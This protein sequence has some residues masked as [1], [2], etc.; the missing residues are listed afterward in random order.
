MM[1]P[2][3][4]RERDDSSGAW[5]LYSAREGCV[6]VERHA[7]AVL[8]VVARMLANPVQQVALAEHDD[9]VES[10]SAWRAH[11]S[12]RASIL[13]RRPRSDP[14]LLDAEVVDPGIEPGAVDPALTGNLS[15]RDLRTVLQAE[16][17]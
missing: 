5:Q 10:L 16:T 3:N 9:V 14:N 4:A 1:E 6:A 8:V 2:T 15:R 11:E 17:A 12:L 13:P 7:R